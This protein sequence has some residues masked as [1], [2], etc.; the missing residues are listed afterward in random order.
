MKEKVSLLVLN[1]LKFFAKIQ[2]GKVKLVQKLKKQDLTIVGITGSAGKTSTLQACQAALS[3]HFKIKTNQGF[4]S[5]TGLPLSILGLKMTNYN[6]FSWLII[7]ILTPIKLLINWQS[8]QL[9]L[10]EMGIDSPK[11]P[12]NM[13]YLLS[14]TNVD[15]AILLNITSVHLANFNSIDQLAKE[16]AKLVN[17]AKTAIINPQDKLVKKYNTNKNTIKIIPTKIKIKD[18]YLPEIYQITFGA[19][20]SLAKLLN[21][22]L[23]QAVQNIQ[24]NFTLPSSRSSILKGI[25]DTAIIDSS[26]NSSPLAVKELLR[27]LNT[28]KTKRIAVLGDM[29]ELGQASQKEHRQLY[30]LALDSTDLIISVG[31]ETKQYFGDQANKFDNW[32]T[33]LNFLKKNIKGKETILVKGSQNTIYL[34][35]LVKSILKNSSDSKKIC[36]QSPYWLKTKDKFKQKS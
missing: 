4:N 31:P 5:E 16:K 29:R 36:R 34:E 33:A 18:H 35:E 15:I 32:W 17:Q 24:K 7:M 21:I 27:F 23:S 6:P 25:R 30:Q 3:P 13:E 14:I 2:L 10:L 26:Y 22:S 8:Y 28:F 1:Y 9:L 11:K 20:T 19:A 12:K